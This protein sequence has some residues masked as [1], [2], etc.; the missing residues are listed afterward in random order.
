VISEACAHCICAVC[1]DVG[2]VECSL[3]RGRYKTDICSEAFI[4]PRKKKRQ[5]GQ[6]ANLK[7]RKTASLVENEPT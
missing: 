1:E 7:R 5:L 2:C 4:T 3:C 6:L